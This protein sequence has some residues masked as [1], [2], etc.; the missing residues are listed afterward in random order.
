MPTSTVAMAS[1][2]ATGSMSM[3][4]PTPSSVSAID[5]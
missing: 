3:N 5:A 1:A 4:C 2:I